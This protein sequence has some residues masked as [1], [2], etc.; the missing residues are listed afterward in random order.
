M[1]QAYLVLAS[2][3]RVLNVVLDDDLDAIQQAIGYQTVEHGTTFQTEDQLIIGADALGGVPQD[4]FWAAGVPFAF[5]GNALLV[6]IDPQTGDTASRPQMTIDEFQR[7]IT[8]A[9]PSHD[10]RL[11]M[12]FPGAARRSQPA[13]RPLEQCERANE[14]GTDEVCLSS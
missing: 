8:F 2:E 12:A 6:G 13:G 1:K 4:R 5:H 10:W 9:T 11:P 14:V 7:L 3:R